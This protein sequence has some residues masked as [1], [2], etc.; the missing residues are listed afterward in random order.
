MMGMRSHSI[1]GVW[2]LAPCIAAVIPLAALSA[3]GMPGGL[4]RGAVSAAALLV[5]AA[6]ACG[7]GA[8]YQRAKKK[9]GAR[10]SPLWAGGAVLA[11]GY[12][13]LALTLFIVLDRWLRIAPA[14]YALCQG[15]LLA[16]A[17]AAGGGLAWAGRR[18][19][20]QEQDAEGGSLRRLQRMMA[21][22]RLLVPPD[23]PELQFLAGQLRKADER[24]RFSDPVTRPELSAFEDT[25]RQQLELLHD[26]LE[27]L[28]SVGNAPDEW[29]KQTEAIID[30]VAAAL[31]RRNAELAQLKRER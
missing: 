28:R 30:E 7:F 12:A 3:Y 13:V 31:E 20:L 18:A 10:L 16:A 21:D 1:G 6:A 9:Q 15:W 24:F 23:R 19:S 26:Q 27:L 4:T 2:M 29:L 25:L 5:S 22:I 17:L 8:A 14:P 11:A